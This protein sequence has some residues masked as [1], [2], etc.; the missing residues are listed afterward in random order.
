M[1]SSAFANW[2]KDGIG[3]NNIET[4]LC[5]PC[6]NDFIIRNNC[7]RSCSNNIITFDKC[8]M[9][10]GRYNQQIQP[11]VPETYYTHQVYNPYLQK[12]YVDSVAQIPDYKAVWIFLDL[13]TS[14]LNPQSKEFGILE[15][16]AVVTND[17]FIVLDNFH[18]IIN[19]P[20]AVLMASSKW[21]LN[22]FSSRI[23]GG[24]DLFELCRASTITEQQ[25]G[26]ML[27]DFIVK[28]SAH[29]MRPSNDTNY[30]RRNLLVNTGFGDVVQNITEP[31]KVK[32]EQEQKSRPK[33]PPP[34]QQD[35]YRVMLAGCSVYNDR[36]VLLTRFPY[37]SAHIGHK[38]VDMTSLLEIVR[39]FR[40]DLLSMLR[41]STG[42]HRA[43]VDINE[44]LN[45][46]RWFH[47]TLLLK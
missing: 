21:C 27:R 3:V 19:Q 33:P 5:L 22:H 15:I 38:T 20:E 35:T 25:A 29:R 44:S 47:S 32:Q 26:E 8:T 45:V 24:N 34:P 31:E 23:T 37:L 13:E 6:T 12:D 7:A 17:D 41:C 43:Q 10:G 42:S 2:R 46:M 11:V 28:H 36:H 30:V 40:P 18:V 14:N 9:Y 4:T 1:G 39:R 16:A